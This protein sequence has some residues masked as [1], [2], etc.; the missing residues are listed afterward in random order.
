MNDRALFTGG[1]TISDLRDRLALFKPV[2]QFQ[3][4]S[5]EIDSHGTARL[6]I[7]EGTSDTHIAIVGKQVE[8]AR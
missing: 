5:V 4:V 2:D 6:C 8:D 1:L 3:K 7:K